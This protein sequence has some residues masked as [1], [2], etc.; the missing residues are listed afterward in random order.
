MEDAATAD[1]AGLDLALFSTGAAASRDAG[2][3]VRRGR[4]HRDRQ[5][6]GLAHGPRRAPGR[7]RGQRRRPRARS[8]KGIVANPNCTTMVAMPVLKP[9]ARRGRPAPPRGLHLPGRVRR[10]PGRRGRAGRAAGQDRRRAGR[11]H[12]RRDRGRLPARRRRSPTPIAYNVLPMAGSPGRRRLG[13]DQRGAEVPRR[14][15][16][17][18][19]TSPTWRCR[20]PASGCRSSPATPCPSMAEFER[21]LSPGRGRRAPRRGAGGRARPTCRHPSVPPGRD[22]S[23]VGRL[24]AADASGHRLALFVSGDNLRKGAALNAVQIAEALV[25]TGR[26]ERPALTPAAAR[27]RRS[28]R[29][30]RSAAWPVEGTRTAT[31][32]ARLTAW[33]PKRS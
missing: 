27:V 13:R 26:S 9:A 24:R 17:D 32:L 6:L 2:P 4:R 30:V 23:L 18:P 20:A 15:P 12:L 3:P 22:P 7:A 1:L 33:S 10:R 28:R 31:R 16:Q 29:T 5:L 19:R 25:A 11:A 21:P 8:G 14:E